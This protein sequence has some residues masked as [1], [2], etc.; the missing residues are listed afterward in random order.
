MRR[1][2]KLTKLLNCWSTFA[3]WIPRHLKLLYSAFWNL[4]LSYFAFPRLRFLPAKQIETQIARR[5]IYFL[6]LYLVIIKDNLKK[7]PIKL[8]IKNVKVEFLFPIY[9]IFSNLIDF[10]WEQIYKFRS[11]N[12]KIGKDWR[13]CISSSSSSSYQ[14]KTFVET[15]WKFSWTCKKIH[16]LDHHCSSNKPQS[17]II[18][19]R[20]TI[21][22]PIVSNSPRS[23][24]LYW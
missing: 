1:R 12:R 7:K 19:F 11:N 5:K 6:L 16:D 13:K 18:N 4:I 14:N 10:E 8:N 9:R 23:K 21:R 3:C 24:K 20:G 2:N 22:V 17:E 15:I